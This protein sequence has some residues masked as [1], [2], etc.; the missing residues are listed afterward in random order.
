MSHELQL[1]ESRPSY[2]KHDSPTAISTRCVICCQA[3]LEGYTYTYIRL[4]TYIHVHVHTAILIGRVICYQAALEGYKNIYTYTYIHLQ[5]YTYVHVHTAISIGSVICCRATLEGCNEPRTS[6]NWVTTLIWKT[7]LTYSYFDWKCD[8][9]P[10]SSRGLHI[11]IYT[12]T[13]IYI[14]TCAY[15]YF[16]WTCDLLPSNS[17]GLQ[18]KNMSRMVGLGG[19]AWYKFSKVSS[20]LIL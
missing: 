4:Q 12:F 18:E 20:V 13:N 1:I 3:A 9:L 2:E 11:H 14:C 5:T 7:R 10:S 6:N 15:S 8:L 19:W 17:R 16:D